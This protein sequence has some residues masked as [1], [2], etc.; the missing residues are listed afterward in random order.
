[1]N[2]QKEVD[3]IPG[4]GAAA[5]DV[6]PLEVRAVLG[7]SGPVAGEPEVDVARRQLRVLLDEVGEEVGALHAR[8]RR[9]PLPGAAAW[10]R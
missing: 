7:P 1:M 2:W 4:I 3:I 5:V 8:E 9:Q 6:P 10:Y